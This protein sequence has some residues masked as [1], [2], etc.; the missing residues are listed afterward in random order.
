M[1]KIKVA[2]FSVLLAITSSVSLAGDNFGIGRGTD[3]NGLMVYT[4]VSDEGLQKV[5]RG[6]LAQNGVDIWKQS[7]VE[8]FL[9]IGSTF[10]GQ[11]GCSER[12][13]SGTCLSED[14]KY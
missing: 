2:F 9:N 4:Y 6:Y 13:G 8:E 10:Y 11:G 3:L 14:S 1:N 7:E 5:S 12:N